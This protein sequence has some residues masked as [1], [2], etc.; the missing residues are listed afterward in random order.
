MVESKSTRKRKMPPGVRPAL[1]QRSREKRDRLI[2]A[3]IAAFARDGY[4]SA[5]VV[6]IVR[7]AGISVGVFY[8]RFKD[9]RGFFDALEQEFVERGK[10]NWDRFFERADPEWSA[11]QL[12]ERLM[13]NL[14]RVIEDNIGFFRALITLGHHDKSVVG[15]GVELDRYGAARLQEYLV[16]RGL[17]DP[18]RIDKDDV[19]F[20][21]A[22]IHK[23]LVMTAAMAAGPYRASEPRTARKLARMLAG[24]L[25]IDL[26]AGE[27]RRRGA[28]G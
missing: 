25:D 18:S 23:S 11:Q 19:Y 21:L 12:L 24:Y 3:G 10:A 17:I 27:P 13:R 4:E 20:A 7:D 2:R 22:T 14:G 5:R 6:D 1:Q 8:Q 26:E 15:P 9:K 28:R 16:A